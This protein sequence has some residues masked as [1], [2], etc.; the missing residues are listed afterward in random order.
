MSGTSIAPL[1]IDQL[2][3]DLAA[4]M[5]GANADVTVHEAW[6]GPDGSAEMVVF[7]EV[8]WPDYR[9]ATI[10]A[11]RQYRDEVF[12]LGFEVLIFGADDTSPA[13][14]K[15]ARDRAFSVL[16]VLEAY[17]ATDP[18]A[19]LAVDVIKWAELKPETAGPRIFENG[20]AYRIAGSFVANARLT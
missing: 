11:G 20:W 13:N 15:P 4:D 2:V 18:R 8:A 16:A 12:T 5:T 6:P 19:G 10:K 9:I 7:G 17:L 14:P 1:A 3:A